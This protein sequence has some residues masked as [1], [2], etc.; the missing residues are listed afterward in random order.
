MH[1]FRNLLFVSLDRRSSFEKDPTPK[2]WRHL[3]HLAHRQALLGPLNDGVHQLPAEQMPP[4][5]V[6]TD[7]DEKTAKIARIY[8]VHEQH[9]VELEALLKRLM[10]YNFGLED[11]YLL[12]PPDKIHGRKLVDD[13]FTMGNFGVMD[14]RGHRYLDRWQA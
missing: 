7:W 3:Y 12:C 2:V 10:W 4:E 13:S 14:V 8:Q 9:I 11:E 1:P 5:D 6:L